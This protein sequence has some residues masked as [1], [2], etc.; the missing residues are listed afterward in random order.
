[1]NPFEWTEAMK[2]F[3]KGMGVR[4]VRRL[5]SLLQSRMIDRANPRRSRNPFFFSL[6]HPPFPRSVL[7]EWIQAEIES[8]KRALAQDSAINGNGGATKYIK[9]GELDRIRREAERA[10]KDQEAERIRKERR[11]KEEEGKDGEN[12]E[13]STSSS[14]TPALTSFPDPSAH[15]PEPDA[16]DPPEAFNISN[17][18]C[19]RRLRLKSQ[20]IRLFGESD[21]SRRLRLRAL[22]LIEE[23]TEGQRNDFMRAMKG[24]TKGLEMETMANEKVGNEAKAEGEEGESE[25]GKVK[26]VRPGEEEVMVDLGLVKKDKHKIYPQIYHALKV[27]FLLFSSCVDSLTRFDLSA[28]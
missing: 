5:P 13:A 10:S 2:G 25:G 23:R 18:E 19:I 7:M 14:T 9:R 16:N 20:P 17:P 4:W 8:K 26:K 12:A 1:M 3:W 24:T 11:E 21:R 27:C 6:S 28:Y 15:S 22:Q